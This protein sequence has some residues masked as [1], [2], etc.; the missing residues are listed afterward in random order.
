MCVSVTLPESALYLEALKD[1]AKIRYVKKIHGI[2]YL[3]VKTAVYNVWV[4]IAKDI[5]QKIDEPAKDIWHHL[6]P[7]QNSY[8]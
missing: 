8:I 1:F 2:I 3:L 6:P 7:S 4:T 5:R